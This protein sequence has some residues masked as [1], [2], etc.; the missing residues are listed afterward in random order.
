MKNRRKKLVNNNNIMLTTV[1][2]ILLGVLIF[3]QIHVV[4]ADHHTH[5]TKTFTS[6]EIENG[7]TLTSIAEEYAISEADYESYI[8][9]V[10]NINNLKSDNIHTGCY[11]MIPIYTIS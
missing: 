10:K 11:L 2:V 7:D 8:E 6:I 3:N 4:K 5:Y 1:I 9:E